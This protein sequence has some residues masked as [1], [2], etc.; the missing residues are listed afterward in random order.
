MP[1]CLYNFYYF[2]DTNFLEQ[3]P[4]QQDHN[5]SASKEISCFL[6]NLNV[7]HCV[8]KKRPLDP[9]LIQLNPD[10]MEDSYKQISSIQLSS[11][12]KHHNHLKNYWRH[13]E[14][15][16]CLINMCLFRKPVWNRVSATVICY[17]QTSNKLMAEIGQ[18]IYAIF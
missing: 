15:M 10:K 4:T 3:D 12:L 17:I 1:S 2:N 7:C 11:S 14:H 8:H 13:T 5:H 9:M 18:N 16:H 6:W